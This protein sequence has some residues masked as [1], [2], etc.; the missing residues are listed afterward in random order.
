VGEPW[1]ESWRDERR[2]ISSASELREDAKH[3]LEASLA[4][5]FDEELGGS[6]KAIS[7]SLNCTH[8]FECE[9]EM[10]PDQKNV[11][12]VLVFACV[13]LFCCGLPALLVIL[14]V[15]GMQAQLLALVPEPRPTATPRPTVTPTR[16]IP[17]ATVQAG[18]KLHAISEDG[19]AMALPPSWVF[20]ELDPAT[21]EQGIQALKQKNPQIA[22]TLE[23]Q[24]KVLSEQ[25]IKF[26]AID[27]ASGS[28]ADSFYTNVNVMHQVMPQTISLD[29][30]V[31]QS[32][33]VVENQYHLSQP[34][35]HRR[36]QLYAME[37]E[38]LR[39]TIPIVISGKQASQIA[40]TQYI[41][42]RGKDNYILTFMTSAKLDGK[43]A[44]VFEQ[45]AKTF[46]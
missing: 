22:Q 30:A 43:Y 38:E 3:A 15:G 10:T 27:G 18:W 1:F 41:I 12:T 2:I 7:V 11:L 5:D 23:Q 31:A 29:F 14:D 45:I 32:L 40:V 33:P 4:G 8:L 9:V 21:M 28:V 37:A 26:Y 19:F 17:T 16:V 36:V 24:G 6:E 46:R 25:G 34:I 39:F 20:Q 44:P 35:K 42:L 13:L